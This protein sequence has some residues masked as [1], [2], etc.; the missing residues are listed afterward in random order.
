MEAARAGQ[1]PR[2]VKIVRDLS[3]IPAEVRD[4]TV[5]SAVN[6]AGS[7][8][9][10]DGAW[11][12]VNRAPIEIV[13]EDF[14]LE[15][16]DRGT[17]NGDDAARGVGRPT[18]Y[19]PELGRMIKEHVSKGFSLATAADFAGIGRSTAYRWFAKGR[20]IPN[21]DLAEFTRSIDRAM[22]AVEAVIGTILFKHA[23]EGDWR[24]QLWWCERMY[25]EHW[26]RQDPDGETTA[27]RLRLEIAIM[28]DQRQRLLAN[29][30]STTQPLYVFVPPM[31]RQLQP[32]A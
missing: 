26:G 24:T 8:A 6:E 10:P 9:K 11:R 4:A 16:E 25:P 28:N 21:G 20:L 30:L 23:L 5:E 7:S 14:V 27:Q 13:P 32:A 15:E 18:K 3:E 12:D 22:N 2:E 19:T 29:T 1:G 31:V 17:D